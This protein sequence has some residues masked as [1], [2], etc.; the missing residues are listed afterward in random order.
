MQFRSIWSIDRTLSGALLPVQSEPGSDDNEGVLHISQ[1]SSITGT[2]LSNYLVSY[3][4]HSLGRPYPSAEMQSV[5]STAPADLA[6]KQSEQYTSKNCCG[7]T[8]LCCLNFW[9]EA[10]WFL[11]LR[12]FGLLF[13]SLLLFAR[14]KVLSI[15]VLLLACSQEWTCNFQMIVSLED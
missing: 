12:V 2:S 15:P 9:D 10:W 4:G 5:Y 13:S 11:S 14:V 6:R 1:S 7:E 8:E 3:L